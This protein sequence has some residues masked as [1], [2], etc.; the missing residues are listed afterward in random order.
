MQ[1]AVILGIIL[2]IVSIC[3]T[4]FLKKPRLRFD[5]E[6]LE[7]YVD[8]FSDYKYIEK[9]KFKVIDGYKLGSIVLPH[10]FA[11]DAT[12][13]LTFKPAISYYTCMKPDNYN[14]KLNKQ[15]KKISI[16]NKQFLKV[17]KVEFFRSYME[18]S[19]SDDEHS[20]FKVIK[21]DVKSNN[22]IQII[23][24]NYIEIKNYCCIMPDNLSHSHAAFYFSN[25][26]VSSID[27]SYVNNSN[28][29]ATPQFK[30]I[31]KKIPAAVENNP[32]ILNIPLPDPILS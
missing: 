5:N 17:N 27:I 7:S 21:T 31:I 14:Y 28:E 6:I 16:K 25:K 29:K 18:R 20:K 10:N 32:G 11:V 12:V 1:N 19:L 26:D 2:G 15:H 3:I 4:I 22:N 23:N 13:I 8:M 9:R 24:D 30:I